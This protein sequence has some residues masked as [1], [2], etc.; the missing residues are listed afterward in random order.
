MLFLTLIFLLVITISIFLRYHYQFAKYF[1]L[2]DVPSGRKKHAQ[3]TPL[4]GGILFAILLLQ[5]IF[6]LYIFKKTSFDLMA[7]TLPFLI[8]SV[9]LADDKKNLPANLKLMILSIIILLFLFLYPE[10]QIEILNLFTVKSAISLGKLGIIFTT[11]CILLLIN[12]FNMSDGINGLFLS[13]AIFALFYLSLTYGHE[14]I[15]LLFLI[16]ISLICIILNLIG[17]FFMGD[18]G[19]FLIA[20]LLSMEIIKA[21]NSQASDLKTVEEIFIILMIPGIDMFRLFCIRLINKK[22]PFKADN[23]HLHHIISVSAHSCQNLI[24]HMVLSITPV[25]CFKLNFLNLFNS[26]F[27]GLFMYFGILIYFYKRKKNN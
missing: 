19:V 5:S 21:Y 23:N 7:Y 22:H 11:L 24:F 18:S 6:I 8:F 13:N 16:A 25:I 26:I 20:S 9:G 12:A 4:T 3:P 17:K 15:F 27:L 14:N 10:N 2:L 1:Q